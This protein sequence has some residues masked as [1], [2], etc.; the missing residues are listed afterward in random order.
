[1]IARERLGPSGKKH[2][3]VDLNR[4]AHGPQRRVAACTGG[5]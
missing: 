2:V 4:S 5:R 1:M 3:L